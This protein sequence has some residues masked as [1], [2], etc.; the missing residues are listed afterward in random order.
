[1]V[2]GGKR[3]YTKKN[4]ALPPEVAIR[5]KKQ[6]IRKHFP[7]AHCFPQIICH[8]GGLTFGRRTSFVRPVE[9]GRC[10]VPPNEKNS[11]VSIKNDCAAA[12]AGGK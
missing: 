4:Q 5:M 6:T 2:S 9:G 11:R 1:M 8:A 7:L 3:A 10:K 12:T